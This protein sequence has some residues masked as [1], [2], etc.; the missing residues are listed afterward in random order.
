SCLL[1]DELGCERRPLL[2]RRTD[3]PY[4]RLVGVDDLLRY[5]RRAH[6]DAQHAAV[7]ELVGEDRR[8]LLRS[9]EDGERFHVGDGDGIR[10][11]GGGV[12]TAAC[13]V[14]ERDVDLATVELVHL[15]VD[16]E[17]TPPRVL[18]LARV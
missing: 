17:V 2:R 13:A 4:V 10:L 14:E 1:A 7:R 16:V 3:G 18:D 5:R 11:G 15:V 8:R 6:S 12:G 9:T